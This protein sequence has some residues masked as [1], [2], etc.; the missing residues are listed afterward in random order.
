MVTV[1]FTEFRRK[2]KTYFDAVAH[3][4]TVCV[5]R[6]GKIIARLLPPSRKEPAWK[7]K[8]LRLKIRGVSLS[9]TILDERRK[10]L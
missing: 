2:A 1:N 5:K 6:R 7:A 9:R 4:E 3:G 8:A 10:S